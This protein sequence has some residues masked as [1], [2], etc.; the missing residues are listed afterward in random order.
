[1]LIARIERKRDGRTLPSV[2]HLV[3]DILHPI[4][5]DD[6]TDEVRRHHHEAVEYRAK[7]AE[8]SEPP[9]ISVLRLPSASDSPRAIRELK[10]APSKPERGSAPRSLA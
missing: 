6:E 8:V 3:N 10:Y 1:M 2:K 7:G 9:P 4:R 5:A